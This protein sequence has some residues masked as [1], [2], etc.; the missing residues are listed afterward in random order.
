MPEPLLVCF[1]GKSAEP[2]AFPYLGDS[3]QDT[4]PGLVMGQTLTQI[5]AEIQSLHA[6]SFLIQDKFSP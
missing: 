2:Q 4:A 3:V 1:T 6:S 5:Q